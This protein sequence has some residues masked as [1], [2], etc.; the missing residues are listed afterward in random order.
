ME[1]WLGKTPASVRGSS[2]F[3]MPPHTSSYQIEVDLGTCLEWPLLW[4]AY[5]PPG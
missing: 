5:H 1:L 2:S 4:A 3:T